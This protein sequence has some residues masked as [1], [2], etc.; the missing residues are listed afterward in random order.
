MIAIVL[1]R[2]A[3]DAQHERLLDALVAMLPRVGVEGRG[4]FACDLRGLEGVFGS[5][6]RVGRR[7]V[8]RVVR[9][10]PVSVGI[11]STTFAARVLAERTLVGVVRSVHDARAFLATLPIA[12]LPLE[13][14]LAD[15]LALLGLHTVSDFAALP[16]GAVLDR[17][18][19]A[20][21]RAHVLACAEEGA[22]VHGVA[23]RRRI[24]V[25]RSWE[26]LIG[27]KEQLVFALRAAVDEVAKTLAD[28][29]LA[30]MRLALRL[31]R[32]DAPPLRLDRT[33]LPPT[34]ESAAML[35][36]LRWA[37]DERAE[38]GRVIGCAIEATEVEPER[39]RQI[40]L[41]A[42]DGARLEEALATA[43]YL[44]SRLGPGSVLR[45][46]VKDPQA[47]LPERSAEWEEVAS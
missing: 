37:L 18:G 43:R 38:V 40:G 44:R 3:D 8:E 29:G 15:D 24:R 22:V 19:H 1:A 11:A 35:R 20:V 46:R 12:V 26:D 5:P 32:E 45:A 7:I 2:E 14:K 21:A 31:D 28:D 23:P 13:A 33:I 17:F 42:A 39:G 47:R 27:S 41:F 9:L 34:R 16:R 25:R 30:A 36:S 6:G 4:V 10:A